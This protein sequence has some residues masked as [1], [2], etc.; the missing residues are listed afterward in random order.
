[1]ETIK[2]RITGTHQGLLMHNPAA[3]RS[4]TGAPAPKKIPTPEAEAKAAAYQL[5]SGQLYAKADWFKESLK[6]AAKGIRIGKVGALGIL[7]S[8]I[9]PTTDIL[10][11]FDPETGEPITDYEIDSRRAVI[12]RQGIVRNRP[13]IT[14]WACDVEFDVVPVDLGGLTAKV[15][16][17]FL[18]K[19]GL[20]VGVGDYRPQQGGPFG[21]YEVEQVDA[22]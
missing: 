16:G 17:D 7:A 6:N 20:L 8:T 4:P 14:R 9:F 11:L 3:M 1:M 10:P 5:E 22:S 12:Q 19:A 21:R 18:T 15:I 2:F 13:L